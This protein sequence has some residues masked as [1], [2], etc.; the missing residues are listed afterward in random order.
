MQV[1]LSGLRLDIDHISFQGKDSSQ[2]SLEKCFN[3]TGHILCHL[4]QGIAYNPYSMTSVTL[5][6]NRLA[7]TTRARMI[8]GEPLVL[9]ALSEEQL[10]LFT[11]AQ[12]PRAQILALPGGDVG[13]ITSGIIR[14]IML[15]KLNIQQSI[16]TTAWRCVYYLGLLYNWNAHR[17]HYEQYMPLRG[18]NLPMSKNLILE[19]MYAI[20]FRIQEL[21]MMLLRLVNGTLYAKPYGS[22]RDC[23]PATILCALWIVYS[24]VKKFKKLRENWEFVGIVKLVRSKS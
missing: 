11:D 22:P 14:I 16:I 13:A 23:D 17:V 8:S 19:M 5:C 10:N 1:L 20:A 7:T 6:I 9:P 18:V 4:D 21:A 2:N 24:S 12:A 15:T 3:D